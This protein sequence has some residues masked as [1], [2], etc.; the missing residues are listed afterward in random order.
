MAMFDRFNSSLAAKLNITIILTGVLVLIVS[1]LPFY[2]SSKNSI[3]RHVG[4]EL[5][6]IADWLVMSAETSSDFGD[7]QRAIASLASRENII[8]IRIIDAKS[9]KIIADSNFSSINRLAESVITTQE[10]RLLHTYWADNMRRIVDFS[11]HD[12]RYYLKPA[13]LI[14]PEVNRLRPFVMLVVYDEKNILREERN[15][16][17]FLLLI[18]IGGVITLLFANYFV[19]SR[20]LLRP[21]SLMVKAIDGQSSADATLHLPVRSTDAIGLLAQRYNDME[22]S[23]ALRQNELTNARKHIDGITNTVPI[24]LAY[25]DSVPSFQFV[26]KQFERSFDIDLESFKDRPFFEGLDDELFKVVQPHVNRVFSGEITSF[27]AEMTFADEQIHQLNCTYSP[28][29]RSDGTVAGFFICIEDISVTKGVERKLEDYAQNLELKTWEL[30]DEKAR[31]ESATEAKSEFLAGMSHEIR[32]P[33]NGVMGMLN[34]LSRRGQLNEEQ[35]HYLNLAMSSAN[36]LLSLI[37]D[38]LDFSKIEAGKMHLELLDFNLPAL[39]ENFVTV[40]AVSAEQKGLQIILDISQVDV[41]TVKGDSGRIRQI[42][43]NLVSNSIKFTDSGEIFVKIILQEVNGRLRLKGVV[44]DTG[45]GISEQQMEKLFQ[46]FTQVDTSTTRKYG[47][48]GLGL[49]ISKQ[50]CELMDGEILVSSKEGQGSHFEFSIIL[51]KSTSVQ[52]SL[53]RVDLKK[54]KILVVNDNVTARKALYRQLE[55][56]GSLV[57]EAE[58]AE[59]ALVLLSSTNTNF[60]IAII[61]MEMTGMN[62]VDLGKQILSNPRHQ[63]I[64]LV[65]IAS[66]SSRGDAKFFADLGF[67]AYLPKPVTVTDLYNSLLVIADDGEAL[68]QANPLV[69]QHYLEDLGEASSDTDTLTE[70][71]TGVRIKTKILLVEDNRINQIVAAGLLEDLGFSIDVANNGAEALTLLSKTT[72]NETYG[73]VLMD[74]QMP[75]MDGYECTR[76]IRSGGALSFNAYIPI[77]AMTANA[78]Q[79]DREKCLEAGMSDY[80]TKPIDETALVEKLRLWLNLSVSELSV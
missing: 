6:Y 41:V 33:I 48:T 54:S 29:K 8:S 20:I 65:I 7:I 71:E 51:D 67:H 43:T 22:K 59:A 52:T 25:V 2:Y 44:E 27:E 56:W 50:L 15:R 32:T 80:L 13:M 21:L 46:S 61:E 57:T 24:L 55:S 26:N 3:S 62:G 64:K 77:L 11:A 18:Y 53:P 12:I 70:A 34:L 31:A 28:D 9:R 39:L 68:E 40:M 4:V 75:V 42:L 60:S 63:S 17:I 30:E 36:S 5:S 47:G 1:S 74:C 73:L 19:Q 66:N 23:R 72:E 76:Q 49:T 78:M 38:I 45:I 14:D 79:G 58:N 10:K 16:L 35:I 69:T 37:N